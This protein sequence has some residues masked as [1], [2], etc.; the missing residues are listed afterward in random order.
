MCFG[1]AQD[2]RGENIARAKIH[3]ENGRICAAKD[4]VEGFRQNFEAAVKLF[5][6]LNLIGEAFRNLVKMAESGRAA[7]KWDFA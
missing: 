4:D 5:L 1:K 2:Y 3:E 7:G 6:D